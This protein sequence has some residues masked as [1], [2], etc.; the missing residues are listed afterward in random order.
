MAQSVIKSAK[1]I[2]LNPLK[3][4]SVLNN[5][6]VEFERG[7]YIEA[8]NLAKQAKNLAIDIDQDGF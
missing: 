8:L 2:G 5:T 1:L 7:N 6:K 4:E 3:A